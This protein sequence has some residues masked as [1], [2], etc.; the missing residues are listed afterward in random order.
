M[1]HREDRGS[2][3]ILRMDEGPGNFVNISLVD[4]LSQALDEVLQADSGAVVLTGNSTTF[5]E[6]GDLI[7]LVD[8]GPDY[9]RTFLVKFAALLR[10]IFTLPLPIVAAV[11]GSAMT[12]GYI[13]TAAC[14]LRVMTT[15][16]KARVA[17]LALNFGVP[18]EPTPLEVL[19]YV[20][21]ARAVQYLM[22]TGKEVNPSESLALGLVDE[23]AA[24]DKVL[25]R[26]V[27]I[28][29]HLSKVPNPS[30][31]H[32]KQQLRQAALE[33]LDRYE[34]EGMSRVMGIW[35]AP[36][37]LAVWG[38]I[39]EQLKGRPAAQ[40]SGQKQPEGEFKIVQ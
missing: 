35:T 12:A 6:G 5:I 37:T 32:T 30:F 24:P 17:V 40:P 7:A 16:G 36:Q 19:H 21:P 34:A 29:D 15:D 8:G 38:A 14:D 4:A 18:L 33:Q 39:A 13:L 27:E 23:L 11:N 20:I 10:R 31:T 22:Y 3:A 26:A 1:I 2:V 28:A 25:S 9:I